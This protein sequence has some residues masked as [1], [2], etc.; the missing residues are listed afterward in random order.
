MNLKQILRGPWVNKSRVCN[1][2]IPKV[3]NLQGLAQIWACTPF[4]S[5]IRMRLIGR[6]L[7]ASSLLSVLSLVSIFGIIYSTT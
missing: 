5:L 7:L 6:F 2:Q 3:P 4:G 1:Y